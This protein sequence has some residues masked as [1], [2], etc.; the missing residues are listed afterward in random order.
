MKVKYRILIAVAPAIFLFDQ[1]SK[2]AVASGI[3]LGSRVPVIPGFFD[4]AHFRNPGAAF[5][6]MARLPD[7]FRVPF[8]YAVSALAVVLLIYF[9]LKLDAA[10]RLLPLALSLVLGGI[11]GNV[12]DRIR[13]G[14]VIDFLSFHIGD[15]VV[16]GT[17]LGRHFSVPMEWPAF[18]V[19]DAAITVAMFLLL[20]SAL[21]Q[22]R[23]E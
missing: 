21:F 17:L 9:Y 15:V 12:L 7:S 3:E 22:K 10:E 6:M 11:A 1:L 8:F 5:G 14:A 16:E 13:F 20:Y 2:W 4:L 19:A 18:N 23:R